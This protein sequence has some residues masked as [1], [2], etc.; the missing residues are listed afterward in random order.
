[1]FIYLIEINVYLLSGT[2]VITDKEALLWTDG[3]Y[4]VQAD[5]QLDRN[6]WKLMKDGM[7]DVPSISKWLSK[8]DLF[9]EES[10]CFER[11]KKTNRI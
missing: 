5:Q 7:K 1:M 10:I 2:C 8:V 9:C 3:R 6:C 4:F 11:K